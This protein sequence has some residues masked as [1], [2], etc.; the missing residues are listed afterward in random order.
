MTYLFHAFLRNSLCF[1]HW[2]RLWRQRNKIILFLLSTAQLPLDNQ[3]F[4]Y[5]TIP[6][7]TSNIKNLLWPEESDL[8]L[9][10]QKIESVCIMVN[11]KIRAHDFGTVRGS[12][13]RCES[14]INLLALR[15]LDSLSGK[16]KNAMRPMDFHMDF[17]YQEIST[18]GI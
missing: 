16:K 18:K 9:V 7:L 4:K 13:P 5:T 12:F 17:I 10:S 15:L 3:P 2:D 8:V 6:N 14:R 1:Q 11:S